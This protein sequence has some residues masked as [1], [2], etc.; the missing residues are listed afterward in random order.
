MVTHIDKKERLNI[1][2]IKENKL[3]LIKLNPILTHNIIGRF[4][5]PKRSTKYKKLINAF[6]HGHKKQP[7]PIR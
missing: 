7:N 6:P 4:L 1:K 5:H 3:R 2:L